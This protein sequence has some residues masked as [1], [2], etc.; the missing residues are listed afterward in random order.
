[1][2]LA[3]PENKVNSTEACSERAKKATR[4]GR[5]Q[6][7]WEKDQTRERRSEESIWWHLEDLVLFSWSIHPELCIFHFSLKS[8][9]DLCYASTA[10]SF[11]CSLLEGKRYYFCF[12]QEK[13]QGSKTWVIKPIY[14]LDSCQLLKPLIICSTDS[15]KRRQI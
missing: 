13:N 6:Y 15:L 7:A 9:R 3:G 10:Q 11:T 14:M 2:W 5:K 8:I 12:Y 1:M 4:P